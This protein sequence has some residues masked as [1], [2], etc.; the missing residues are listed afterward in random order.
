MKSGRFPDGKPQRVHLRGKRR[1]SGGTAVRIV[2][3]GSIR[4]RQKSP[5]VDVQQN[6]CP[7]MSWGVRTWE[8]GGQL[9]TGERTGKKLES[10][11]CRKKRGKKGRETCSDQPGL[12]PNKCRGFGCFSCCPLKVGT[13]A[14][15]KR[16]SVPTRRTQQKKPEDKGFS[17]PRVWEKRNTT[18]W[19]R[20]GPPDIVDKMKR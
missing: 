17:Q 19:K 12:G 8:R 20:G 4:P 13:I 5:H 6:A 3:P 2:R 18:R 16:G 10:D 15:A 11:K 1:R 14:I 7:N 9:Q